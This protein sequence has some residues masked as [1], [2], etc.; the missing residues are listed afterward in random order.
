[1]QIKNIKMSAIFAYGLWTCV[2]RLFRPVDT[3]H[4]KHRFSAVSF[5]RKQDCS[6]IRLDF[7]STRT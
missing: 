4:D 1:M 5:I 7:S 2:S 6:S 3:Y